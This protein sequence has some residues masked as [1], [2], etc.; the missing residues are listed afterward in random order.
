M[1]SSN[2]SMR[3]L[4]L[5][6]LLILMTLNISCQDQ[7]GRWSAEWEARYEEWQPSEYVMDTFGVRPGMVVAEI[8][9]GNGRFAVRLAERVGEAG[10]KRR[11]R[12][13]PARQVIQERP[14]KT[15]RVVQVGFLLIVKNS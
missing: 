10:K 14:G 3:Q 9:A 4:S 6:A 15:G 8:G 11:C 2:P 13:N 12:Q 5:H 7:G 1:S